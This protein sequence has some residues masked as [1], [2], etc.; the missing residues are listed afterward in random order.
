VGGLALVGGLAS[1]CFVR[2]AGVTLLGEPRSPGAAH[3]H[4]S[5]PWMVGPTWLLALACIAIALVPAP[6]LALLSGTSAEILRRQIEP[7]PLALGDPT[8]IALF[9]L[10]L[11]AMIATIGVALVSGYRGRLR[12]DTTW[13][14][15]YAAPTARMQYTAQSFSELLTARLLPRA[16]RARVK[17]VTP[18]G[19]FPSAGAYSTECVDPLTRGVY[20]PFFARWAARFVR[21]RWVQQG[22]LNV[23][24]VYIVTIVVLGLTWIALRAWIGG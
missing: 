1:L 20:E 3:A 22:Q 7:G 4:E 14:C 12:A 21:L 15:G 16:L 11:W 5:S 9:N 10:A 19:I 17:E 24:V 23:Y 18:A 13:G 2:L 8:P 6:V